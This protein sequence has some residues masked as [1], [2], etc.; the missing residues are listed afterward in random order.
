M[1]IVDDDELMLTIGTELLRAHGL[2]V[3]GSADSVGSAIAGLQRHDPDLVLV[4]HDLPDGSAA[5]VVPV[6]R[7]LHPDVP[8]ILWTGRPDIAERA[9]ALGVDAFVVKS[10]A[11]HT[12]VPQ[13]CRLTH[14]RC[15]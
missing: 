4:D 3:L 6:L 12:L 13:V 5:D 14:G 1:L 9:Q 2:E 10:E 11:S 7:A 15:C 8:V